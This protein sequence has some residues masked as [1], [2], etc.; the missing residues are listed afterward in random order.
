V[1]L[2]EKNMETLNESQRAEFAA[3]LEE[4]NRFASIAVT[5]IQYFDCSW[6]F[7]EVGESK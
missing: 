4:V 6:L 7:T 2:G 1:Q 3:L 5:S